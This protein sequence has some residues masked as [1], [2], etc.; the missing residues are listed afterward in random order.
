M[1]RFFVEDMDPSAG[2]VAI[3]GAEL[4]HLKK[5]LRLRP[6]E[7]V[8]VFNGKGVELTGTL[9]EVG[10][11]SATVEVEGLSR[12]KGEGPIAIIL[13]QG[14][15]KGEKPE[16]VI[17]KATELGVA[18]VVFYGAERSVTE[19]KGARKASRLERWRK[20]AVE[21]A[22]QCERTVVPGVSVSEGLAKA[23]EC[24]PADSG[25]LRLVLVEESAGG[26]ERVPIKA[27]LEGHKAR[28]AGVVV[29]VGPEGGFPA[30]ELRAVIEAGFTPVEMGPRVMRAETAAIA[31]VAVIQYALGDME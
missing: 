24:L 2:V 14:L 23:V 10:S 28:P 30:K 25:A 29:V 22:K 20:V 7:R 9:S 3:T 13:V 11:E 16:L 15:I 31:A 21:A 6:G 17:Q 18:A 19:L 1:R 5:V 8:A 12:M 26:A 4:A 27:A